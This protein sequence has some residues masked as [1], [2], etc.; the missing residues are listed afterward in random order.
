MLRFNCSLGW[1]LTFA[2]RNCGKKRGGACTLERGVC[3]ATM[4]ACAHTLLSLLQTNSR[5]FSVRAFSHEGKTPLRA[6]VTHSLCPS[7]YILGDFFSSKLML[8]FLCVLRNGNCIA[9]RCIDGFII[10]MRSVDYIALKNPCCTNVCR[11]C[12]R[13]VCTHIHDQS[14]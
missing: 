11:C 7:H 14:I 4:R 13:I 12:S 3:P 1:A 2:A 6:A 5:E 10:L 9:C 8:Y